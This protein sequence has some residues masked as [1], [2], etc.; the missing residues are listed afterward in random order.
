MRRLGKV[1]GLDGEEWRWRY[2]TRSFPASR[3]GSLIRREPDSE[4]RY[5]NGD[6]SRYQ[7]TTL[8]G[9]E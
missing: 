3:F 6:D 5:T 7:L 2:R 4:G 8:G 9:S 1:E